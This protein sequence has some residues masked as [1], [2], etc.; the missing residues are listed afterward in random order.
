MEKSKGAQAVKVAVSGALYGF[1]KEYTYLLPGELSGKAVKGIRVLVPFG[2]GNRKVIGFVTG[3][4]ETEETAKLKY[5]DSI[6]EEKPVVTEELFELVLWLREHT[7]CTYF[8]AFRTIVPS[9]LSYNVKT[10]Y[11]LCNMQLDKEELSERENELVSKLEQMEE[12]ERAAF[13][14]LLCSNEENKRLLDSLVNKGI[15][16][17]ESAVRRKVGDETVKLYSLSSEWLE[18]TPQKLTKKQSLVVE[19]LRENDTAS[20]KEICYYLSVTKSIIANLV[21]KEIICE[22]EEES[23]RS[24]NT[25]D[26]QELSLSDVTLSPIQQKAY[27]G[28]KKLID[29]DKPAGALLYGVTGSGKTQVFIKLIEHTLS[30]G[31]TAVMLVPEISLTPQTVGRFKS[32]FGDTVAVIHSNLSMGQRADEFKRL[33]NGEARIAIGTR[34]AVFAP[35]SNIGLIV[36]DE[37]GEHSYKSDRA[38]RYHARDVAIKRCGAN[39]CVL[40]MASATPSLESYYYAK[41]GRYSLFELSERFSKAGL[42]QVITVDMQEE[43][44]DGSSDIISPPLYE[45][46]RETLDNGEQVILLYNRR[47]FSTRLICRECKTVAECPNCSVALTYHKANNR[48]MCHYC[49]YSKSINSPCEACSCTD[50]RFVGTGTQKVEDYIAEL[51]PDARI[52]R[53]DADTTSSRY[54][55]E[56]SFKAFGD[57]E[58]DIMLGTQMIA[59]GLDF[60]SVTLV[61]VIS[62]DKSLYAGDFRSYEKTFSLITQVVGRSGRGER[63]G[64]AYIQTYT[65][66]HYVL[67]FGSKQD[68]KGFY[69]EEIALR[70]TLLYPPF[71]DLCVLTLSGSSE[72]ATKQASEELRGYISEYVRRNTPKTPL[73]VLGPSPCSVGRVGN[74]YRYRIILKCKN[75]RETRKMIRELLDKMALRKTAPKDKVYVSADMNGDID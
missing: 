20:A 36:M 16:E 1:D 65:P 32:L 47:G 71:C 25:A 24:V 23:Y 61:G 40:L 37:E 54:A 39:N 44:Q 38:P 31:K 22:R 64:K 42:P 50:Y 43:T 19:F 41:S 34:S 53:M 35:L 10:R 8:E 14:E 45:A 48:L 49:G 2:K 33:R 57:G 58:Y 51:F 28:I 59:K 52:L 17:E 7:F 18:D 9:G 68:Y 60:P 67:E 74:K 4:C 13:L 69:N 15:L 26:M 70:R 75:T 62:L 5:V 12:S 55:F 29:A 72:Y 56:K 30:M 11:S 27:E 21:K 46:V 3:L 6:I 66:E 73:R 63:Q